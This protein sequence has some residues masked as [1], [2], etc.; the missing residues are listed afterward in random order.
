METKEKGYPVPVK[1]KRWKY[2]NGNDIFGRMNRI[3]HYS[4]A[5]DNP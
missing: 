2:N 4:H 1:D 3:V 5:V